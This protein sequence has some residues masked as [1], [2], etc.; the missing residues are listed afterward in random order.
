MQLHI[1]LYICIKLYAKAY[2]INRKKNHENTS[3]VCEGKKK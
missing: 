2:K 1:I 3:S